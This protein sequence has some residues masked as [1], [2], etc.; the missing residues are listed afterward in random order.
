[1]WSWR[2]SDLVALNLRLAPSR[3]SHDRPPA[4][5][6]TVP[7]DLL[8]AAFRQLFPAERM[9]VFGGRRTAGGV[10][11]TSFTDVTE[12]RPTP[13]HVRACP[14]TLGSALIDLDRTGAHFAVWLHSHPGRGA[15]ATWPSEI[16]RAQECDL[17]RHYDHLV[18]AIAVADGTIRLW[19]TAI[20]T[21]LVSIRWRGTGVEPTGAP[22]VWQLALS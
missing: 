9:V 14:R 11:V 2:S 1:M 6:V 21:G 7:T 15:Q 12:A 16:D 5:R 10:R 13:V 3:R 4:M 20:D 17:L 22:N 8:F 19:G 18:C